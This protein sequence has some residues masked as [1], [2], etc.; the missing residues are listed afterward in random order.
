MQLPYSYQEDA[1]EDDEQ[2]GSEEDE[3]DDS[4]AEEL[5][6]EVITDMINDQATVTNLF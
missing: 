3:S 2:E 5:Q 6:I 1:F 4:S